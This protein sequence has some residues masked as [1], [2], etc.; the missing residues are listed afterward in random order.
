M[1]GSYFSV[2]LPTRSYSPGLMVCRLRYQ[3]Q[4]VALAQHRDAS[5]EI[6]TKS[7]T[8]TRAIPIWTHSSKSG[9]Q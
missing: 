8:N 4:R 9:L 7:W 5:R 2:L 3:V 1:A 6:V